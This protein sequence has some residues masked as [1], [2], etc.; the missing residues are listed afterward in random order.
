MS[1]AGGEVGILLLHGFTGTTYGVRPLAEHLAA[2]GYSVFAPRLPGHGTSLADLAACSYLDWADCAAG[3]LSKLQETCNT[4]FLAGHSMGGTLALR[5]AASAPEKVVGVVTMNAPVFL[6]NPLLPLVPVAKYLIKTFPGVGGDL[7]DT[8]QVD[9][10]YD[11]VSVKAVHELMKLMR[12][13]KGLLP[14]VR[15]PLLVI[16]SREDHVVPPTNAEYILGHVASMCKEAAWLANSYHMAPL[17][18]DRELIFQQSG[19]FISSC[20][21]GP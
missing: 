13:T 1:F 21:H 17:D 3:G 15:V 14:R 16:Q 11:K 4:I 10:C 7:K 20:S 12:E 5:L 8:S 9:V 18:F 2:Q 6:A 19:E